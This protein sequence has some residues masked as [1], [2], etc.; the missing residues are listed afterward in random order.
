MFC[1]ACTAPAGTPAA[2]ST[3]SNGSSPSSRSTAPSSTST[4]SGTPSSAPPTTASP[5]A[6]AGSAQGSV[7]VGRTVATG[8]RVPW[9][10]ARLPDGAV[11]VSARD[12]Y[13]IFAANLGSGAVTLLGAVAGA[14]S[15]VSQ[16]GEGGLLGIAVSP[17]FTDDRLVYVYFSTAS[18][19]R[20][21]TVTYDPSKATGQQL[22][23]PKVLVS[24]IPH[25]VHHNGGRLGFGPDGFLYATTGEA[26]NA[27]LAQDKGSLGGKILRMT[28]A[29]KPAPGNPFGTLVWTYGHRNVQGIAWDP[30]RRLWASEFGDKLA[31]ELNL[32]EPGR[33][34]RLA[35]DRGPHVAGRLH[36]PGRPVGHRRGLA[37]RH[38]VCSRLRLD[39][40]PQGAAV[41]ANP[42]ER[43]RIGGGPSAV[44]GRPVRSAPQRP[45]G[46][47]PHAAG[48]DE[49]PRRTND[50][51]LR[52]RSPGPPD[53]DVTDEPRG[54]RA[55][56]L[57]WS[58]S[59]AP[60]V[61]LLHSESQGRLSFP[62]SCMNRNTWS[63]PVASA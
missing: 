14:V 24:G 27:A 51:A 21:A 34:S 19:N 54:S 59:G 49:Q 1:A 10:L 23:P 5:T 50:P 15:N 32:I 31:D 18:D 9:G 12:S 25:N 36:Q 43:R 16:A 52:R 41:V 7:T 4:S 62:T 28:T 6:T 38:R 3:T 42:V 35:R 60:T 45:R 63:E 53:R 33:N 46:G 22:G 55:R 29:G 20:I 56:R 58:E 26:E 13:Q 11:L 61:V 57:R 44:P 40:G 2:D 17:A 47:R 8:I 37:E 30:A 39:G 48:D